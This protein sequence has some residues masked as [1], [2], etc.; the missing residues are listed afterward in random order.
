MSGA[1]RRDYATRRSRGSAAA[2]RP[3][4]GDRD[5]MC[6]RALRTLK[7]G[8]EKRYQDDG[9]ERD[10][11]VRNARAEQRPVAGQPVIDLIVHGASGSPRAWDAGG[12]LTRGSRVSTVTNHSDTWP[13]RGPRRRRAYDESI[14]TVFC[15]PMLSVCNDSVLT[16]SGKSGQC[17]DEEAA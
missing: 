11:P 9:R 15:V 17:A 6:G 5:E 14:D 7:P 4:V 13:V 8:D 2:G 16:L 10:R 12:F 1:A 3:P